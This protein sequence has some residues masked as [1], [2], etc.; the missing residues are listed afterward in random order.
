LF[1][2]HLAKDAQGY[3][4]AVVYQ[5]NP[6]KAEP[7]LMFMR[8]DDNVLFFLSEGPEP[9]H[10]QREFQQY[11]EPETELSPS[12]IYPQTT[13]K[14]LDELDN[15]VTHPQLPT[16]LVSADLV[17]CKLT[18]ARTISPAGKELHHFVSRREG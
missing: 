7:S 9:P 3:P 6:D 2:K 17:D 10:R 1:T 11:A 18:V 13:H 16:G 14:L 12:A 8:G 4:G 15:T 5:L